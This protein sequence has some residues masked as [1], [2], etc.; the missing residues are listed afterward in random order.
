MVA[1]RASLTSEGKQQLQMVL[2]ARCSRFASRIAELEELTQAD[3]EEVRIVRENVWVYLDIFQILGH[4][5][6]YLVVFV[7]CCMFDKNITWKKQ[8]SSLL[9]VKEVE[10]LD[11]KLRSLTVTGLD[12]LHLTFDMFFPAQHQENTVGHLVVRVGSWAEVSIYFF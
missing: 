6:G 11:A 7:T 9:G 4:N 3:R 10:K 5:M 8:L 2:L 1:F 12:S